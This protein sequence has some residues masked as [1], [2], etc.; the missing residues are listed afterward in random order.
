MQ[1]L[2]R[3]LQGLTSMT[4][5]LYAAGGML[6]RDITSVADLPCQELGTYWGSAVITRPQPSALQQSLVL[7]HRHLQ[8]LS[9]MTILMYAAGMHA[10]MNQYFRW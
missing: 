7:L 5:L 4:I 2:H 1:A 8:V 6:T 9:G 10:D 3:H